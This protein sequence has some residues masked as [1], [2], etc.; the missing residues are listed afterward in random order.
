M[1]QAGLTE[2]FAESGSRADGK[3]QTEIPVSGNPMKQVI[4]I[5]KPFLAEKVVQ[6]L[7]DLPLQPPCARQRGGEA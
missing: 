2:R 4:A 6:A 7:A 5:V 1:A 3:S